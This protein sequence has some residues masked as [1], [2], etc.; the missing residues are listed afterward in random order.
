MV[1]YLIGNTEHLYSAQSVE[2]GLG[3]GWGTQEE[4]D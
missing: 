2:N 4:D 3:E 1:L